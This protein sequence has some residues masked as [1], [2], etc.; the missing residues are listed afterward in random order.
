M[1]GKRSKVPLLVRSCAG[2]RF[3]TLAKARANPRETKRVFHTRQEMGATES[4]YRCPC[5]V[6]GSPCSGFG[7][8]VL[9]P[10]PR[11]CKADS[12]KEHRCASL[13]KP[14][15]RSGQRLFCGRHA[16]GDPDT[17]GWH[18]GFESDFAYFYPA[19]SEQTSQS[20]RDRE[21]AWRSKYS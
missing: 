7:R 19:L 16:G 18:R 11:I 9:E 12:R 13:R 4:R 1:P 20:C 21:A 8:D 6:V 2:G 3:G 17:A 5:H 15:P 10:W 14:K